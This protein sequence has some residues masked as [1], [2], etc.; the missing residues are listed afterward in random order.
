MADVRDKIAALIAARKEDTPEFTELSMAGQRIGRRMIELETGVAPLPTKVQRA[1]DAKATAKANDIL[2]QLTDLREQQNKLI[3]EVNRLPP[4]QTEKTHPQKIADIENQI[5]A[6]EAQLRAEVGPEPMLP[7]EPIL[8]ITS[9]DVIRAANMVKKLWR[10]MRPEYSSDPPQPIDLS[11]SS[12]PALAPQDQYKQ[13]MTRPSGAGKIPVFGRFYDARHRS[14]EPVKAAFIVKAI[15]DQIG[16]NVG[17]VNGAKFAHADKL[18]A[19]D[20]K[21]GKVTTVPGEWFL[22]DLATA[23]YNNKGG[24]FGLTPEQKTA[25]DDA[26]DFLKSLIKLMADEGVP[27]AVALEVMLETADVLYERT[28]FP[29]PWVGKVSISPEG[30]PELQR[31][32]R[33]GARLSTVPPA[34]RSRKFKSEKDGFQAGHRYIDSF[35]GRLAQAT[36]NAYSAI[37]SWRLVNDPNLGGQTKQQRMEQWADGIFPELGALK[38]LMERAQTK[39]QKQALYS[40]YV[41]T[42]DEIKEDYPEEFSR[43]AED[44]GSPK[45]GEGMVSHPLFSNYIFDADTAK[46]INARIS[47]QPHKI[48]QLA[49]FGTKVSNA[50]VLALDHS[51]PLVQGLNVLFYSLATRSNIWG[52][53]YAASWAAMFKDPEYL[54]KLVAKLEPIINEYIQMGGSIGRLQDYA[55]GLEK[56][57]FVTQL[58]YIGPAFRR[59]GAAFGAMLDYSKIL[60]WQAVRDQVP[61]AEW[62]QAIERIEDLVG[63]GR[64]EAAGLHP[65]IAEAERIV[66]RAASYYRSGLNVL[67]GMF[68]K[69]YTGK[70]TR[71]ALGSMFAGTTAM[72]IAGMIAA[73]LSPDEI[74]RKLARLDL[75]IPIKLPNG[76]SVN[77]GFSNIALALIKAAVRTG[78]YI[79]DGKAI[80]SGGMRQNPLLR[81][82]WGHAGPIPGAMIEIGM[83]EDFLGNPMTV[84]KTLAKQIAPLTMQQVGQSFMREGVTSAVGDAIG[85]SMG[86]A[87]YPET[88]AQAKMRESNIEARKRFGVDYDQLGVFD[89]RPISK[90]VGEKLGKKPEATRRQIEVATEEDHKRTQKIA[91]ALPKDVRQYLNNY[92]IRV[93]GIDRS[94]SVLGEDVVLSNNQIERLQELVTEEYQRSFENLMRYKA[95]E[96][97]PPKQR[98]KVADDAM[99]R[100]KDRAKT[101]FLFEERK[102]SAAKKSVQANGQK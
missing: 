81:F 66:W 70:M 43:V 28:Y 67:A 8:G 16:R 77:L 38:V 31:G 37:A 9:Q 29:R 7:D 82:L 100:A 36:S 49:S 20:R 50:F 68:D 78:L 79:A 73:G 94:I 19:I 101:R 69:G 54:P 85:T 71:Q 15:Q 13:A 11:T 3:G 39:E 93:R 55:A 47:A 59:A 23:Y 5:T 4:E 46:A 34:L 64:M 27:R 52:K 25:L 63:S 6:L 44:I 95:F 102:K 58:K 61:R 75:T 51:A 96:K 24:D 33:A 22:Q 21:T 90:T 42:Y 26:Q 48:V 88:Y 99:R 62:P 40:R 83:A 45:A 91:D 10:W 41:E 60:W 2:R 17:V 76:K 98:E 56:G 65:S 53:A 86:L 89:Q 57:E 18:F 80:N 32:S 14:A 92:Q 30:E 84:E 1:L 12:L 87:V 35:S 97:M 74:W 72:A